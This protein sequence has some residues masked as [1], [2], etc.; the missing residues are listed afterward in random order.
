[1]VAGKTYSVKATLK[2]EYAANFEFIDVNGAV[3]PDASVSTSQEFDYSGDGNNGSSTDLEEL[4]NKQFSWYR[5]LLISLVGVMSVM[6]LII[7]IIVI[8]FASYIKREKAKEKRRNAQ[9]DIDTEDTPRI[10]E[11]ND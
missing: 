6:T 10:D 5:T 1:M 11:S 4:L 2:P 9:R 3:L 8:L 7:I